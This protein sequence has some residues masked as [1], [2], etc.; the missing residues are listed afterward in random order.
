[1]LNLRSGDRMKELFT[2]T[3]CDFFNHRCLWHDYVARW[4]HMNVYAHVEHIRLP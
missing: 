1:M 2:L 3:R 4:P